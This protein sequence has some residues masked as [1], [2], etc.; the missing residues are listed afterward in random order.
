VLYAKELNMLREDLAKANVELNEVRL[1]R[2]R[3]G[4]EAMHGLN[5]ENEK[6][7][8]SAP[9]TADSS[10]GVH[11]RLKTMPSE[12]EE[13]VKEKDMR[14]RELLRVEA[15]GH[16]ME[17]KEELDVRKKTLRTFRKE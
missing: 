16:E 13:M 14:D 6:E 12:R 2:A 10:D 7:G 17:M 1:E 5:E 15:R 8:K 4:S 11:F 9:E 3:R